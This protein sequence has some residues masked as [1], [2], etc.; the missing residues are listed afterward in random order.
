MKKYIIAGTCTVLLSAIATA[1]YAA[2]DAGFGDYCAMGMS[3]GQKIVTDCSITWDS[4][5]GK[6]YCFNSEESKARFLE[7]PEFNL[8]RA[9]EYYSLSETQALAKKMQYYRSKD[10]KAFLQG[11]IDETA[12]KNNGLYPLYDPLVKQQRDVVFKEIQMMRTLHGYGFFPDV[13]FH[14]KDEPDKKYWVDFWIKPVGEKDLE[15]IETRI[16]K[17]PRKS[18]DDWQLVTRQ[19][20]PWWWIPASEHPG[21]SE[22]KRGW[23][24]MSA[25]EKNIL[26]KRN[27]AGGYY[28]L[29]DRDTGEI[30]K[31]E[32]IGIHQ[33]V[34]RLTEDGRFF[35]CTDFRR[36]GSENEYYDVDFWLNDKDGNIEVGE[37]RIHKIPEQVD[38]NWVQVPKYD[39]DDMDHDIVP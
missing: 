8:V 34:R 13:I 21:E 12:G 22:H 39:F 19:P 36:V 24:I 9:N 1:G 2:Q 25:I 16:Y 15:L 28:S 10:V 38:G 29:E 23:E 18:G 33:P 17:G 14:D 26:E 4:R 7:N 11:V 32:Y 27:A 20:V 35:A 5:E 6:T 31:L 37:V 3:L 30:I